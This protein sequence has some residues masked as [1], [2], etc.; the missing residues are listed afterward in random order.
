MSQREEC[1]MRHVLGLCFSV[2]VSCASI[3]SHQFPADKME[4]GGSHSCTSGPG[5]FANKQDLKGTAVTKCY[6]G[7]GKYSSGLLCLPD[8]LNRLR[9]RIDRPP[10]FEVW[11]MVLSSTRRLHYNSKTAATMTYPTRHH[12]KSDHFKRPSPPNTSQ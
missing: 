2:S 11:Q 3:A 6:Y 9:R 1:Q 10:L 7:N 5:A 8:S 4:F 12:G